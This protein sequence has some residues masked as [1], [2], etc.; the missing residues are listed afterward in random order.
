V[1]VQVHFLYDNRATFIA[2][3]PQGVLTLFLMLFQVN[4][5][6]GSTATFMTALGFA[7]FANVKVLWDLCVESCEWTSFVRTRHLRKFTSLGVHVQFFFRKLFVAARVRARMFAIS[8]SFFVLLQIRQ[9]HHF[10]TSN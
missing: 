7:V 5:L 9:E 6:D 10:F 4:F 3:V 1:I 8:A 2:T